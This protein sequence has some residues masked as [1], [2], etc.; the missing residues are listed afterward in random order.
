L[1]LLVPSNW[2]PPSTTTYRWLVD[3]VSSG[4]RVLA[5]RR[6]VGGITSSVHQVTIEPPTGH[7]FSVVL[8]QWPSDQEGERVPSIANEVL[9]L[10]ALTKAAVPAPRV[11]AFSEDVDG[12]PSIVMTYLPGRMDLDPRDLD[13]W[14]RQMAA[15]LP[16]IHDLEPV[17][18]ELGSSLSFLR[19]GVPG[20]VSRVKVWEEAT[21]VLETP[22]PPSRRFV[23]GDY[24]HFNLLWSRGR[25]G[26]VVDWASSGIGAPDRDIGH[27]R[28]NLA[29]LYSPHLAERFRLAYEAEAGR[30]IERWWDVFEI[31]CYSERWLDFI[32]VQVGGRVPVD[33]LGMHNRVEELLAAALDS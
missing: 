6:L 1:A 25:L 13:G 24:Q 11:L 3:E 16:V 8:R 26:G 19:K 32:P 9:V 5:V 23:H 22:M 10:G 30:R 12:H 2:I 14:I 27:C 17:G 33:L 20:W 28:L 15:V 4:A 29:V 7:R 31:A 18:R 21:R